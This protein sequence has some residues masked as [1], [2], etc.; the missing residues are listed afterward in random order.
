MKKTKEN[1]DAILDNNQDEKQETE[2]LV[3]QDVNEVSKQDEENAK[4]IRLK[5]TGTGP[6]FGIPSAITREVYQSK[7]ENALNPADRNSAAETV[8]LQGYPAKGGLHAFSEPLT[9]GGWK[10]AVKSNDLLRLYVESKWITVIDDIS[11]IGDLYEIRGNSY[12]NL[13]LIK[14]DATL[15]NLDDNEKELYKASNPAAW[16]AIKELEENEAE[17]KILERASKK[18]KKIS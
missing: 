18:E 15:E 6:K 4:Q 1:E 8:M 12:E 2:A 16:N 13:V 7:N 5:Y 9:V 11:I 3:T 17:A 14:G 10:K